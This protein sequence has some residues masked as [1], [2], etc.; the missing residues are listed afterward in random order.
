MTTPD[1]DLTTDPQ[2]ADGAA[3]FNCGRYFEAHEVW[4]QIWREC[5]DTD[6]RFVQSLIHAAVALYQWERGNRIGAVTQAERGRAKAAEYPPGYLGLD[7]H[8][9]WIAIR[10]VLDPPLGSAPPRVQFTV[11]P[12][13]RT[14]D[15]RRPGS[16]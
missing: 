14:H 15:D 13:D 5:P 11:L 16:T 9:L 1:S 12:H 8:A 4:E 10:R 2:L 6:R 3:L 7:T